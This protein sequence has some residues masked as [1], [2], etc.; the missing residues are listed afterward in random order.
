MFGYT[1]IKDYELEELNCEL[2]EIK[3]RNKY[4]GT[5][6]YELEVEIDDLKEKIQNLEE[7]EEKEQIKQLT[8]LLELITKLKKEKKITYKEMGRVIWKSAGY[9]PMMNNAAYIPKTDLINLYILQLR[10]YALWK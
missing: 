4:R 6:I 8:T 2:S 5:K 9:I 3:K 1:I 7:A 10:R